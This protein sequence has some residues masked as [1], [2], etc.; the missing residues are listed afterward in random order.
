MNPFGKGSYVECSNRTLD[1][2]HGGR[3]VAI[4]RAQRGTYIVCFVVSPSFWLFL[5]RGLKLLYGFL[6]Y[7]KWNDRILPPRFGCDAHGGDSK[8]LLSL[9]LW[10]TW[11]VWVSK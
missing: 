10:S 7:C 4:V 9:K 11:R 3:T 1:R 2:D 5:C 8:G 6:T